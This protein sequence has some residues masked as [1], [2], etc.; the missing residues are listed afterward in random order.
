MKSRD[1]IEGYLVDLS[2]NYEELG[3]NTWLVDD[4]DKGLRNLVVLVSEP[5]LILR[6]KVM[7]LPAEDREEFYE[8]LL[9]LNAEDMVHGAYALEGSNVILIDTLELETMDLEEF[10]ASIEAIGLALVQHYKLLAGYRRKH[11]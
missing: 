10:R 4:A 8:R 1:K 3:E 7:E 6:V 9:R 11:G 2:Y 5:L